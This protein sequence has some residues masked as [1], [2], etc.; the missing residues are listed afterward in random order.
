MQ[1][2]NSLLTSS[3]AAFGQTG[4]QTFGDQC[5]KLSCCNLQTHVSQTGNVV[6][7]LNNWD[8]T[9]QTHVRSCHATSLSAPMLGKDHSL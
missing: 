4:F 3:G 9:D 1:S 7:V 5:A 2:T 8:G 6:A